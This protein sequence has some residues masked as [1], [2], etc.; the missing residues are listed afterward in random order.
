MM[1]ELDERKV[2]V[3]NGVS[4]YILKECRQE[5]AELIDD[6]IECSIK[7]G[8]VPKEWKRADVMPIYKNVNKEE[9]FNYR[10]V[11]LTSIVCNICTG[12]SCVTNLLSFYSRVM[13]ITQERD[14][15]EDCIYL[16]FKKAFDKV[17]HKRLLW[18]LEHVGGLKRTLKNWM[19]AYLKGRK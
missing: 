16:D 18:N 17:L 8:K 3:P 14:G 2:I 6:I 19:E 4:G 7:T 5:M 10:P 1:K 13:D 9:P 12:R 11:S 15:W